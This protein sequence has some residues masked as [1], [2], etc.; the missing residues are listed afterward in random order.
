MIACLDVHYDASFGARAAAVVVDAWDADVALHEQVVLVEHVAPYVPG[1]FY[2]REL[3]CLRAALA[4]LPCWPDV[5]VVDGHA[6]LGAGV[7]G[8]GARL[9]EAEPR[10]ATVVGVAKTRFREAP[11]TEVRRG[12]SASPLF[13]DEAGAPID[14]PARIAAMHGPHR[15]PTLLRRVDQLCRRGT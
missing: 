11:A 3:P 4:A 8:L 6:W 15:V 1:S 14:A 12:A 2:L 10:I 13:V 5:V 9:L 7:P